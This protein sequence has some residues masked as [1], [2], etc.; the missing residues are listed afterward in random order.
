MKVSNILSATLAG[1]I[2]VAYHVMAFST[3]LGVRDGSLFSSTPGEYTDGVVMGDLS[4]VCV[5][6]FD[7]ALGIWALKA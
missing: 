7:V 1:T 3:I 5:V 2:I 4:A 6:I